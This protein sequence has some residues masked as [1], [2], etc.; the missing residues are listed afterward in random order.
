MTATSSRNALPIRNALR[1]VSQEKKMTIVSSI[2]YLLGLPM[3]AGAA[4]MQLIAESHQHDN[5]EVW[6]VV[7]RSNTEIYAVIGCFLLAAAVFMGMFAAIN[8]FTEAHKKTKVD[9]LYA[10]PLTGTQRFFSNYAGGCLMYIV[11]YVIS[12][13]L[14]WIIIFCMAPLVKWGYEVDVLS[15]GE[16]LGNIGKLVIMGMVGLLLL[17]LLYYSLSVLVT[18][19]CGTLFE[20]IYTNILLNCL[21]PGAAALIIGVVTNQLSMDFEYSWYSIGFMSP[22][23]GLIYMFLLLSGEMDSGTHSTLYTFAASQTTSHDMLPR[24]FRWLLVIL[25]LSAALTAL[26]WFLYKRRRAEDTGKPFV[27]VLAYYL[28]LTL[29]TVSILSIAGF[30]DDFIGGAIIV[31]GIVYF[32]M[33]VIRKRGFKRFWLSVITY[34]ATVGVTV[35]VFTLVIGT[36]CFG[37]MNYVPAAIGVS[38]VQLDYRYS[39]NDYR[40][41]SYDLEFTDREVINQVIALHHDMVED[42]KGME[43]SRETA[44]TKRLNQ[45]MLDERWCSISYTGNDYFIQVPYMEATTFKDGRV[46]ILE[47]E[48]DPRGNIPDGATGNYFQSFFSVGITYYTVTGSAVHRS[49]TITADELVRLLDITRG[50]KLYAQAVADGLNTRLE[51]EY[52]EYDDDKGMRVM[53]DSVRFAMTNVPRDGGGV[54]RNEHATYLTDASAKF[55]QLVDAYRADLEEMTAADFRTAKVFGYV[56]QMP[57]Y[58]KCTRTVALLKSFGIKE[59]SV[60]ERYA[61]NDRQNSG[62]SNYSGHKNIRIYAPSDNRAVSELY[63]HST[64]TDIYIKDVEPAYQDLLYFDERYD[65]K[66]ICPELYAL[67]G[68]ARRSYIA[69]EDC[70]MLMFGDDKY[71]IPAENADLVQKVIA[72]GDLYAYNQYNYAE[73]VMNWSNSDAWDWADEDVRAFR[74]QLG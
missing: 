6:R 47:K 61:F 1:V 29:G 58:E 66:K 33:E 62:G 12:C 64:L 56:V 39:D 11:P 49:Y 2:L 23:G 60:P 42:R 63:P 70:Y 4:M 8:S 30:E 55:A 32:I 22:I 37:R 71:L 73:N 10:L 43:K 57:V 21:I 36:K 3:A 16:F 15:F 17:M 45:Q 50:T 46:E 20:S 25:L 9:M 51:S 54:E 18:V 59:F 68:A 41:F 72:K 65:L 53:P 27:Y 40:D 38:S 5:M 19:C 13:I 35:G 67:L 74:E 28:M 69:D 34:V 7:R 44:V 52:E 26:A 48:E 31:S 14:S 24:Y